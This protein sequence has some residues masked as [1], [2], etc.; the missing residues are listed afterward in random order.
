MTPSP[1]AD[2]TPSDEVERAASG[3]GGDPT[4]DTE[5]AVDE[6]DLV[7][8][9]EYARAQRATVDGPVVPGLRWRRGAPPPDMRRAPAPAEGERNA[10]VGFLGQYEHAALCTLAALHEGTL[11][12]V[13]L[14]DVQAGQI[15]DFQL[16][17]PGQVEAYQIKWSLLP[18]TVGFAA[19]LRDSSDGA[20]YI[21]QLADGWTRLRG[22]HLGS[23]VRVH[24]VT[25]EMPSPKANPSIPRPAA[26]PAADGGAWSFAAFLA[27]AWHPVVAAL[28]AAPDSVPP[29]PARWAPA[30]D[31]LALRSG[32]SPAEWSQF[33]RDCDLVF[34]APALS[35]SIALSGGSEAERAVLQRDANTLAH[36]F[37]QL[38]ARPDRRVEFATA[39]LLALLGWHL[40]TDFRHPHEFPDP[41][42]PYRGIAMTADDVA[43]AVETIS[44]GYVAVIG[45]PGSGKSTLLTR[46]LRASTHRVVR[47]YAYVRDSSGSSSRRGE[48]VNFFHDLTVALDQSGLR[49][50]VA[51]PVDDLDLLIARVRAQLRLAA[52]EWAAGGRR[53]IL[54][55]D[56]LDHIPR[57]Q[58]PTQSLLVH[59]PPPDDVPDGVLWILGTQTD[60]LDG[61]SARIRAQLEAPGRRISMRALERLDV[62]AIVE[63]TTDLAPA[64]THAERERIFELSGGHP[65][66]LN[67]VLNRLR[68]SDGATV[69][70][71]LAA[72][73]PFSGGIDQQY[74]TLWGL[75]EDDVDLALLLG[76]LARVR[77]AFRLSWVRAWA[78]RQALHTVTTALAYLFRH[79]FGGRWTFFHNSFRAFVIERTRA[80]PALGGDAELFATLAEHCA[81]AGGD[82]ERVDELYYRAQAGDS[83]RALALAAPSSFRAQ[84]AAGRAAASIRDD[85]RVAV[86]AA[87]V[88]RDLVACTRLLLCS[89]EFAQR[90][91]YSE[92]LP[93][94]EVRLE[95]GDIDLALAALRDG[96]ILRARP[97][98]ALR[99]S[100]AL[101]ARG[102]QSE[103]RE[104]FNL[105]EPLSALSVAATN[106]GGV[107]R[108]DED[109]LDAWA[110]AAPHFRPVATIVAM[111][112][113]VGVDR[114]GD[115]NEWDHGD[116]LTTGRRRHCRLLDVLAQALDASQ[117]WDEAD[118][119]RAELGGI[120]GA[121][122]WW[123]WSHVRGF[124]SALA[125]GAPS[126]A[127]QRF[128][129]L[130]EA[131]VRG[132]RKEIAENPDAR[133]AIAT[134][135]LRLRGDLDADRTML[136]TVGEP[137]AVTEGD[138]I[139]SREDGW[140]LFQTRFALHRVHGAL[141]D[142]R[143]L[144]DI[145]PDPS[146]T[147]GSSSQWDAGRALLTSFERGVVLLGRLAGQR[148]TAG[149]LAA[150]DFAAR[151]RP[152]VR[153]FPP[154]ATRLRGGYNA[155]QS[156][157]GF[158]T[159]LVQVAAAHGPP[160]V[161]AL[162]A[163]LE[164]EWADASR[165][166]AWPDALIRAIL[167]ELQR[168]GVSTEWI[169]PRLERI[170]PRHYHG[171]EL[172]SEL[173]EGIAQARAWVAAE[174]VLAARETLERVLRATF[175]VEPKDDQ[176]NV[177]LEWADRANQVDPA[178]APARIALMASAALAAEGSDAQRYLVP[179]LLAAGV[180]LGAMS[181]RA[182][183]EWALHEDLQAWASALAIFIRGLAKQTPAAAE[184]L[185]TF[186]RALVLPFVTQADV[187]TIT[188]LVHALS[189]QGAD[190]SLTAL[191]DAV[192]VIAMGS[193]RALLRKIVAMPTTAGATNGRTNVAT[194]SSRYDLSALS[195][196]DEQVNAFEGLALT[197]RELQAR[198]HQVA[199]VE[200][201]VRRVRPQAYGFH[202][203]PI[204]APLIARS[205]AD[206]L[207]GI[208][209]LLPAASDTRK[210]IQNIAERL[211]DLG[212]PRAEGIIERLRQASRAAGWAL[213]YDGGSRLSAYELLARFSPAA[214]RAAAWHALHDDLIAGE[215]GAQDLFAVWDRIVRMLAPETSPVAL[216]P[217]IADHVATISANG[218]QGALPDLEVEDDP[219]APR[220][221]SEA[222]CQ[223]VAQYLDHPAYALAQGAQQ[224]FLERLIAN[225]PIAETQLAARLASADAP[226]DG[227]LLVL[228]AAADAG[229]VI[230]AVT[231][232]PLR[233]LLQSSSFPD[234]RAAR[235]LLAL[236]PS[237]L[238]AD[239][240]VADGNPRIEL[241]LPPVFGL[242]PP[243][244]PPRRARPLPGR[245]ELLSAPED[246]ADLVAPF[247]A[248]L[249]LLARWARVQPEALY[250]YVAD[251]ATALLP[252]GSRHYRFDD[253]SALRDE[254]RR[255]SLEVTYRRPRPRR[256]E[257]AM[258]GAAAMLVDHGRL[259][260]QHF[261]ALD[262]LFRNADPFFVRTFPSPRPRF[263]APIAE[264]E[265]AH[266]V[267][268]D[269][270]ARASTDVAITG[271][272]VP[273]AD[274]ADPEA[275]VVLAEETWLRWLDWEYA[276]ETRVGARLE[277]KVWTAIDPDDDAEE[278]PNPHD[279]DGDTAAGQALAA[280]VAEVSHLL[281]RE[282]LTRARRA[283]SLVVRNTTFRFE[284][285]A[286]A[287]LAINP[288]LAEYLGWHFADDGLFRWRD[289]DGA[290][291]AESVWWQDGFAQL[292]PPLR[293]DEVGY[294][295]LV[296]V[297]ARAWRQ[298]APV[299]GECVDWRRVARLAKERRTVT[300]VEWA[301][302]GNGDSSIPLSQ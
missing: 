246:A 49:A 227:A 203:E 77:G 189:E 120:A 273:S 201:L 261:G 182:L 162:Q 21:R 192:D 153:L 241:P 71:T 253:E 48:A 102:Q 188:V 252:E 65:L 270:T 293:D 260:E 264:R 150:S 14:A 164:A 101:D 58:R 126:R 123:F 33:L 84:F 276:T 297:S 50:G 158:Y 54:L 147:S 194:N 210:S 92:Q 83:A 218:V 67:Y 26:S 45:S 13:R 39:E 11:D 47:Y 280:H 197:V 251:S 235:A 109:L 140:S 256:I 1:R 16:R 17:C 284:T 107:D 118:Q 249:D 115:E 215:I 200:D 154:D 169:R 31:A 136:G 51:L 137:A 222:I 43:R 207:A 20:A 75:A 242:T 62:L 144:N 268:D 38:V 127:E 70:E 208:G 206:E 274:S 248:E 240:P 213:R 165:R 175:G 18:G 125:R 178:Q 25:N 255:M 138:M 205:T 157:L 236:V 8:Q 64:P 219:H 166:S 176:L 76:L 61:L 296:R 275:W 171:E 143:A 172:E 90:Q 183:V 149:P 94:A 93:L 277:P 287:W 100:V 124:H 267:A 238:P 30:M 148:W 300:E 224:F 44:S 217:A 66:A 243:A 36:L 46:T 244:A 142:D 121:D 108:V 22:V 228:R 168:V 263:V 141:G 97:V 80:L 288:A 269:W 195:E 290:V 41:E 265:N 152:L 78:P 5:A 225:D 170:E 295:W 187:E 3:L 57:E 130:R 163:T 196:L 132:D 285:P 231:H 112:R 114:G 35:A 229:R 193:T 98:V 282:Y 286:D 135:D 129:A 110:A 103:A 234:R 59:L 239:A 74:A 184:T 88:A 181:A 220:I 177:C 262:H 155:T 95:L 214:G 2:G 173:S 299:A 245:G 99:A 73:E 19:F 56:G 199:D 230:P 79:E 272:V 254:M 185:S 211:L 23:R 174:D 167:T 223:L 292:R 283:E 160:C 279:M 10:V 226:R 116:A 122:G 237:P 156:R 119:V 134:G 63:A 15:D 91:Y 28:R 151:I 259:S 34:G 161:A 27:E 190:A 4:R 216:W 7:A 42:I 72:V 289:S 53:T 9:A 6:A 32:L 204:L 278:L 291:V 68:H 159:R 117:R 186:Y 82:P 212:D 81:A 232:D 96:A 221:T 52:S 128:A 86:S 198:V 247:R 133:V 209:I 191:H 55:V 85:L 302:V 271:R 250:R 233:S 37:M 40:R 113:S 106:T 12:A 180:R 281:V 202:W 89:A 266:S 294:G 24:F 257:R 87:M 145:V 179:D 298:L 301:P 111:I 146:R 105:A 258:A 104:V 69:S 139:S 29:V 131:I 60:R